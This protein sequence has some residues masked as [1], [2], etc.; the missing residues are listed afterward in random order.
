[1]N[2]EQ[3]EFL[4]L[5]RKL[6]DRLDTSR[7]LPDEVICEQ[8]DK[9][10]MEKNSGHY[11][12]LRRRAQLRTEL[13]NSVRKLD[14]LQELVD[15]DQVTEIMVNGLDG[16]FIEENGR[17]RKWEKG[18]HSRDKIEDL[19]QGIAAK[20]NRIVNA[21]V[22]IVDARLENGAR[23]SMVLPPIALNGPIITIRQF[24]VHPIEMQQLIEWGAVTEEA[25]QFLKKLVI[26][27]YNIFISGGT[28]SGKTTFLNALSNYIPKDERIITI[29]DNAELQIRGVANLVRLGG[30]DH[31]YDPGTE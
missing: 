18:F 23:V 3:N 8:I 24:P 10:L 6:M 17:I 29:E 25:V 2:R 30:R 26:A 9:L 16:I 22:P 20:S 4:E 5:Q 14:I 7:E 12:S 13:F 28:G 19:V 31:C 1:M 21:T 11:Y 15:D 27:G